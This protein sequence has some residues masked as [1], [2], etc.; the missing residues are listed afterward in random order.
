[1]HYRPWKGCLKARK[2]VVQLKAWYTDVVNAHHTLK[3]QYVLLQEERD[4][5]EH[6]YQHLCDGW[7]VELEGKQAAFDEARSR[8]LSQRCVA[9]RWSS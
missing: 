5:V 6:Q 7:K 8:L 1:M 3:T 9:P 4:T 2:L